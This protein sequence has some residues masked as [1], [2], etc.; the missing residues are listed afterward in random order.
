[1]GL[2]I[3]AVWMEKGGWRPIANPDLILRLYE[4]ALLPLHSICVA[5]RVEKYEPT[6]LLRPYRGAPGQMFRAGP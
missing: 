4:Y 5:S 2:A 6:P 3:G 1:M